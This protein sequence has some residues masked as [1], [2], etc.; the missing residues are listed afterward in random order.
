MRML[1]ITTAALLLA[2]A[3]GNSHAALVID[4]P[5]TS[6]LLLGTTDETRNLEFENCEDINEEFGTALDACT[7]ELHYKAD[8]K[9]N[10]DPEEGGSFADYYTTVFTELDQDDEPEGATITWSGVSFIECPECY[11][12]VKD[13]NADPGQYLFDIGNWN[14]QDTI[15][16]SNFWAGVPGAISN[17][18]IWSGENGD[19]GEPGE[20]GGDPLPVPT[21]IALIGVGA[22]ALGWAT[23]KARRA[24][25]MQN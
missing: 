23:R 25:G 19:P 20:P 18:A 22:F 4:A 8:F 13:G 7:L 6:A 16:L 14:G 24:V 5:D 12:L 1:G 10:A 9:K 21:P 2:V 11:L 17:I 3:G 15:D